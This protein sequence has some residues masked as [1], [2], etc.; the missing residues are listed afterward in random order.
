LKKEVNVFE[1]L[2]RDSKERKKYKT[3]KVIN[4]MQE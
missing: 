3:Q 4:L 2:L 1:R